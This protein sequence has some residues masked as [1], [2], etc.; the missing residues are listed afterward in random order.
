MNSQMNDHQKGSE[1]DNA[2]RELLQGNKEQEPSE[3]EPLPVADSV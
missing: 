1:M 2:E 3:L